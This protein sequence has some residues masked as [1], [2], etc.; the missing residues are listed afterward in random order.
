[1]FNNILDAPRISLLFSK[2][3]SNAIFTASN[4]RF[5]P[6]D[7]PAPISATPLFR[8]TTSTSAKST[9]TNPFNVMISA[10]LFAA[11]VNT[12][13]AIS[14]AFDNFKSP[15]IS[16]NFSLQIINRAST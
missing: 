15:Y 11:M 2:G 4:A 1:M 16:R 12:L 3:D 10:M 5:S 7:S 14:N 6:T 8:I 13:S 9:F